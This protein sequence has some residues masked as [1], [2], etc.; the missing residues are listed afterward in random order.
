MEHPPVMIRLK[1]S[2]NGNVNYLKLEPSVNY[3]DLLIRLKD[4]WNISEASRF[5]VKW[6]DDEGDLC[7]MSTQDELNEAVRLYNL[8]EEDSLTL[9]IFPGQPSQ[10][11]VLCP[12]EHKIY[13]KGARR[14][15]QLKRRLKRMKGR[16]SRVPI[17]TATLAVGK[18]SL[19]DS[20]DE[21]S[22]TNGPIIG[23]ND[24]E[25]IKCIG[26]G[27]YAKV[28]LVKLKATGMLYAMKIIK[29][30]LLKEEVSEEDDVD[31]VQ[32]EKN[33]FETASNHPFLVGLHS[34][35]QSPSRLFFVIEYVNGG[36]LM[37]HMQRQRRLPEEHAR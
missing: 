23:M 35:F 20:P 30:E 34:C 13:R 19:K 6:L 29:K 24:F 25:L 1:A 11:G 2:Y 12:G 32:T 15:Y 4:S 5:T 22:Q 37:F 14:W 3:K 18:N 21:N 16:R 17:E 36:D 26:R 7:I 9:H 33:V 31:W 8:N 28:L 10:P 27:S